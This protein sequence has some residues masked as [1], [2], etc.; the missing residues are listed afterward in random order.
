MKYVKLTAKPDTWFKEGTEVL[1][2]DDHYINRRLTVEEWDIM[3]KDTYQSGLFRGLR[4]IEDPVSEGGG[5][6]GGEHDGDG[7]LCSYDEFDVEI[8]NE[9]FRKWND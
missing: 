6:V 3:I 8:V 1:Y 4:I 9:D 5:V 7:E 2:E